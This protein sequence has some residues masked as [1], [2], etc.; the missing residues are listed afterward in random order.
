MRNSGVDLRQESQNRDSVGA[1]NFVVSHKRH[2]PGLADIRYG[3]RRGHDCCVSTKRINRDWC[4]WALPFGLDRRNRLV[5]SSG[6]F[7]NYR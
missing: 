3:Y 6:L 5:K 2:H 1:R 7:K 4:R